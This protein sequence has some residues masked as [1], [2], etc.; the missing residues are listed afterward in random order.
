MKDRPRS[1]PDPMPDPISEPIPVPT[2]SVSVVIPVY[3]RAATIRPAIDSV[4]RQTYA[5]FELIVVDDGSSDDTREVVAAIADPRLRL[6]QT[7]RNMGASAARNLGT[8]E[9]RAPWVAFQ[10]SDDEWLPLKLEKQMA[11]L[12]ALSRDYVAVYC[13]MLVIGR[14]EGGADGSAGARPRIAYVPRPDLPVVEGDILLTLM[15]ASV[16]S[17][18]TLVVRR[19]LMLQIGG[20]DESFRALIDR[21]CLL[22]LAQL[23]PIA[24][25]DE[26]LVLQRFSANSI[27]R[28][29]ELRARSKT[30]LV[31]KHQAIL[32][33]QPALL[34][35]L[36]YSIAHDLRKVGELA[37][38]RTALAQARALR[39]RS[40]RLRARIWAMTAAL[41]LS[42]EARS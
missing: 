2:P 21:E 36:Y 33:R 17:T 12:S 5:D 42:R 7:P 27:T 1:M 28:D 13:G 3:N 31:E 6:I 41:A 23:G 26:P 10:D 4:L 30:R 40:P 25:V 22:R 34:A 11:R 24:C 37:D 38:A 32:A 18:Q 35:E 14:P 16:V 29:T 15:Q 9:A 8:R 19:D 20:F 39:P